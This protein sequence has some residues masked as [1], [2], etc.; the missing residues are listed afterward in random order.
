M[1]EATQRLGPMRA[2][3]L[4]HL[5]DVG[6]AVGVGD[7][8]AAVGLHPNTTRF[9][10]DALTRA[11]LAVRDVEQRTQRGRPKILYRAAHGH[12]SGRFE[13]LADAMVR[14]FAR[15]VDDRSERATDA[16]AAWGDELRRARQEV[17]PDQPPL[18]RLVAA[19]N[20]LGYQPHL[21]EETDPVLELRPCPYA[22]LADADPAV[23]CQLH[24][25]LVRGILGPGQPWTA[26]EIRPWVTPTTCRVLLGRKAGSAEP[27]NA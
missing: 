15:G 27:A 19:M 24:L 20:D 6:D 5:R 3:V 21:V 13:S 12:Q 18:E 26:T 9:H 2:E 22:A 14:H 10:L 23:I 1:S 4:D 16:G 17:E 25:G 11:G 8:A 7:V